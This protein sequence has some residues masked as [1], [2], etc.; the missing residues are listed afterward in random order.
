MEE[1]RRHDFDKT[2]RMLVVSGSISN[3]SQLVSVMAWR[4]TGDKPLPE[5]MMTQVSEVY[6][7]L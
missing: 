2:S 1:K 5:P 4:L 7:L 6:V 3:K